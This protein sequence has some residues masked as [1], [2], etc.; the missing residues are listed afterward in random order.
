M[1]EQELKQMCAGMNRQQLINLLST[2]EQNY[3]KAFPAIEKNA[4]LTSALDQKK[5]LLQDSQSGGKAKTITLCAFAG[6]A[7]LFLILRAGAG[8]LGKLF[9]LF[10]AI[11]AVICA[12]I[13]VGVI[14][15]DKSN[16]KHAAK[17]IAELTLQLEASEKDL[18]QLKEQYGTDIRMHQ[19]LFPK[20]C[21][22]PRYTRIFIS[23]FEDGR[24]DSLKEAYALFDEMLHREKMEGLAQEQVRHAQAAESAAYAA[25]N[26]ANQAAADASRAKNSADWAAFNTR[27]KD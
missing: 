4:Q 5:Q 25:L 16:A 11:G 14:L 8:I 20:Q 17:D 21:L 24:A 13:T 23:Y 15:L 3:N 6:A 1:N 22:Y 27:F 19:W 26:A 2:V 10:L 12:L 18:M 9:Y 7:V